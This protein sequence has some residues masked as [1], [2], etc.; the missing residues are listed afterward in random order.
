MHDNPR[1]VIDAYTR[2]FPWNRISREKLWIL[3]K[4]RYKDRKIVVDKKYS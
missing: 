3:L 2:A 4:A 1:M